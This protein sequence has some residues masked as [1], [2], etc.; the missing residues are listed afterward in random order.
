[1]S[2]NVFLTMDR[3]SPNSP[4]IPFRNGVNIPSSK[5]ASIFGPSLYKV[6]R[7]FL[8]VILIVLSAYRKKL[9]KRL[10]IIVSKYSYVP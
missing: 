8:A 6:K 10:S 3:P 2:S 1:M 9:A 5:E 7:L 4:L